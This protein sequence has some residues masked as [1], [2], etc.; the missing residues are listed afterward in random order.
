MT[1]NKKKKRVK[2]KI[3]NIILLL[4]ILGIL[5]IIG[6]YLVMMPIKNIYISGNE[7]IDDEKIR[8]L[9]NIDNYP[10]F[11]LT[12]KSQIRRNLVANSYIKDVKI[13]KRL[14][15]ILEIDIV[16][17]RI[18]ASN[19]EGMVILSS[20]EVLNNDYKVYDVPMLINDI[21]DSQVYESFVM[22]MEE[23][24]YSILRQISEIEYSPVEVDKE[25]FLFY[26]SDGNVIHVTLTKLD[27]MNKYNK[28]KDKLTGKKG[29]IYL[30]SGDYVELFS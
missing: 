10:S 20:G 1:K 2:F 19:I 30:D 23:L 22:G 29:V 3:K 25:R 14:G 9:A 6:Y 28:I 7:R 13:K 26:M 24:D 16:E 12:N 27:K 18:I 11:I 8:E 21:S 4:L 15:N 17:Y 5:I